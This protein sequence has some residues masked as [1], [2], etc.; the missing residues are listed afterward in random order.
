MAEQEPRPPWYGGNEIP[1]KWLAEWNE[2]NGIRPPTK[3]D[4]MP[5]DM[6]NFLAKEFGI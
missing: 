3:I 6:R 4:G 5:Q 1:A 2:R